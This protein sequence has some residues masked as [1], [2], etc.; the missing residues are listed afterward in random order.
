MKDNN[1]EAIPYSG[2]VAHRDSLDEA[3][4]YAKSILTQSA[5]NKYELQNV[6]VKDV[7]IALQMIQNT[8]SKQYEVYRKVDQDTE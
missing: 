5:N 7:L 4:E 1:L 6:Y 3:F 8:L 2:L